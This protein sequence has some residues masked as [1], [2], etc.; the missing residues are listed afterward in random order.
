MQ[1]EE[2]IKSVI[3]DLNLWRTSNEKITFRKDMTLMG[4]NAAIDSL[5]FITFI[6]ELEVQLSE[7][8]NTNISLTDENA[9]LEDPSPY[10]SIDNLIGY[11]NKILK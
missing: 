4:K 6:T 9:L 11:I 3:E 8:F 5:T 1:I 10:N 7:K 2:I